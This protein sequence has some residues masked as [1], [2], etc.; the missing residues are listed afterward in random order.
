METQKALH[1][2]APEQVTSSGSVGISP[3]AAY[4]AVDLCSYWPAK[5][6][7]KVPLLSKTFA[8][9]LFFHLWPAN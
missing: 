5:G 2:I 9:E 4:V 1:W 8:R 7:C 6:I 3:E